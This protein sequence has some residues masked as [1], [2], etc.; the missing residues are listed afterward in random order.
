MKDPR[1]Y[2][3]AQP[4]TDVVAHEYYLND[5]IAASGFLTNTFLIIDPVCIDTFLENKYHYDNLRILAFEANFP[6]EGRKYVEGYQGYTWVRRD[7]LVYNFYE[8]RLMKAEEVGMDE[9]WEKS[10]DSLNRAFVSM[11]DEGGVGRRVTG[12]GFLT[13]FTHNSVLGK[14]FYAALNARKEREKQ[15][16]R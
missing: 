11:E 10:P 1:E 9:I 15:Q 4:V 3:R 5:S 6:V 16:L 2:I 8:L 12:S 7:Q 13:G 14:R